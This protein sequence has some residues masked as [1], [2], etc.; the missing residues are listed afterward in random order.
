MDD[1]LRKNYELRAIRPPQWDII[2]EQVKERAR[3]LAAFYQNEIRHGMDAATAHRYLV[4][5]L[6]KNNALLLA[7]MREYAPTYIVTMKP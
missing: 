4:E 2:A 7:V 5:A 3:E 6:D 1:L